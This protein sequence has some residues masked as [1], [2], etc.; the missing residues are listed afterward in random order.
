[1]SRTHDR[2]SCA[3][4]FANLGSVGAD[5]SGHRLRQT[6]PQCY[7]AAI[8]RCLGRSEVAARHPACPLSPGRAQRLWTL[9]AT[10]DDSSLVFTSQAG[11]RSIATTSI[12]A[13]T[14]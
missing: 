8:R 9:L 11:L 3:N 12:E 7:P 2:V 4:W 1:M 5:E 6:P 13:L 14:R 10:A